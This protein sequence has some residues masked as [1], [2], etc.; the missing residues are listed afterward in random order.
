[1]GVTLFDD[2]PIVVDRKLAATIGLNEAIVL[3]HIHYWLVNNQ[4]SNTNFYEG[5]YWTF[6]SMKKWHEEVFYFWSIETVKRVFK[7][8]EKEGLLIVGNFNKKGYDRT[9]WYTI[10]Y[11]K[12]YSMRCNNSLGQNDIMDSV[13]MTQCIGSK[14]HNG[15]GQNDPTNTKENTK[16]TTKSSKQQQGL[17]LE[18]EKEVSL[19]KSFLGCSYTDEYAFRIINLLDELNKDSRYLEEK[20]EVAKSRKLNNKQGYLIEAVRQDYKNISRNKDNQFNNFNDT[21]SKY[22][23]EELEEKIRLSQAKKYE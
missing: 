1:M 12:L 20:I 14:C 13:K 23:Q 21:L 18:H 4:K 6:N 7:S 8:L 19:L 3:Q 10:D 22:T 17:L 16:N 2:Y 9:K 11:Q 15:L 5:R